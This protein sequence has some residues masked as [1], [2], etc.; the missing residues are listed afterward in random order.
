MTEWG[1]VG[2]IVVLFGLIG[3]L[4]KPILRWNTSLVENTAAIRG[5]TNAIKKQDCTLAEHEK[6]LNDHETRI[7]LIEESE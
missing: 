2:V 4:I 3:S 5:L 1:V 6:Q 7:R